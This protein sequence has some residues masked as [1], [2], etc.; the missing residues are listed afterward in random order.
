MMFSSQRYLAILLGV[1]AISLCTVSCARRLDK[2]TWTGEVARTRT[3]DSISVSYSLQPHNCLPVSVLLGFGLGDSVGP[4]NNAAPMTMIPIWP[5]SLRPWSGDTSSIQK[6]KPPTILG[7]IT[8]PQNSKIDG[9]QCYVISSYRRRSSH[10]LIE[11][12]DLPYA[13]D[14]AR[15]RF[16]VTHGFFSSF[17]GG[18]A[19]Y[20][21]DKFGPLTE[22]E[23]SNSAATFELDLGYWSSRFRITGFSQATHGLIKPGPFTYYDYAGVHGRYQVSFGS[24][25]NPWIQTGFKYGRIKGAD[26]LNELAY[27]DVGI[28]AGLGCA[29]RFG[30]V[31]YSYSDYFGG[32][33]RVDLTLA[34]I[35][36]PGVRIG[37]QYTVRFCRYFRQYEIK[38]VIEGE[39]KPSD[40]R[41]ADSRS[42]L[43]KILSGVG[44]IYLFP[45]LAGG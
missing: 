41:Y 45:L 10:H 7:T 9:D 23:R 31:G 2:L 24:R 27:D 40:I 8:V 21:K 17:K 30:E 35:A 25:F 20:R 4:G 37:T 28:E 39:G 22:F 34:N 1:L 19:I 15:C 36:Y 42:R 32:I 12:A 18:L 11:T 26:T 6:V 44:L 16:D 3:G 13:M 14:T 29:M 43:I 5:D 33:H 38:L